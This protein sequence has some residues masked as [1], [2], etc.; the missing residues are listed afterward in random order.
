MNTRAKEDHIPTVAW[1]SCAVTSDNIS[2]FSKCKK[3]SVKK[4][5]VIF[6]KQN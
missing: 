1:Q 5:I 6:E 4:H 2:M 3:K